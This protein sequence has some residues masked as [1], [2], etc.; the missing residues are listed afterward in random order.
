M[1]W[2]SRQPAIKFELVT[3]GETTV[4]PGKPLRGLPPDR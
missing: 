1:P 4:A 2:I 3:G